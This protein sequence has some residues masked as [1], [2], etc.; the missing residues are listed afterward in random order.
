MGLA[1]HYRFQV[2][3][4][5]GATVATSD[6]DVIRKKFS[7]G[8]YTFESTEAELLGS[9]GDS[10]TDGSYGNGTAQNNN[11]DGWIGLDGRFRVNISSGTPSGQVYLLY[12]VSE[13]GSSW[14]D[15]GAGWPVCQLYFSS[16]GTQNTRLSL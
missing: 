15:N 10:I 7:S 9:G 5:T 14:P 8:A 13:D 2:F 1:K 12:Q 11:S 3:N 4:D 16:T 6:V